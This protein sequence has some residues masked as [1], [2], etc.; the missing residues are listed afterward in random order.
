MNDNDMDF[1][2]VIDVSV[3]TD[4]PSSSEISNQD[5]STPTVADTRLTPMLDE[6]DQQIV[7]E[8]SAEPATP[9]PCV[10]T[11]D[12]II[13]DPHGD[14]IS[15]LRFKVI[16]KKE[17]VFVGKTDAKG[18]IKTIE[19][20]K[21]GSIFEI[22]VQNDIGNY[23]LAAIGKIQSEENY[24]CLTSPKTRFEFTT[25]AHNGESGNA[26]DHKK[27][28]IKSHNQQP[29]DT[30]SITG[31]PD[32]KPTV[33]QSRNGDGHPVAAVIDGAANWYNIH[34]DNAAHPAQD[35]LT[36][37]NTLVAFMEHQATLD[38]RILAPITS[39]E[40]II[41]M[42]K[43]TYV[44]PAEKLPKTTTGWCAKYVKVGLWYAGYGSATQSIGSGV[45]LARQMGPELI[46]AGFKEVALPKVKI[47][48]G[49]Q[50]IEQPDI[51]FAL[52]GDVIVYKKTVAPNEA[53]HIDVRTYHG[54]ISDFVWPA[55][56]GFP[57]VRTYTVLG[58]YRKYSD[59]LSEARVKA[60]LRIIREHEAKGFADPYKAL[61]WANNQH[62]CFSDMSRHPYAES[63]ED[64]P[65]GAYQIKWE[66]FKRD[67]HNTGWATNFTPFDQD[68]AAVY[69]L[70]G[71]GGMA[72]YPRR[73]ALGYIMEGKVE[74]AVNETKLWNLFAF[75]P[76]GGKQQLISMDKLKQAFDTYTKEYS[77]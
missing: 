66:T 22:H 20:L 46:K 72:T 1:A 37:L 58:V 21:L 63:G 13:N 36:R 14:P 15:D 11:L 45:Q 39:D 54:F 25:Y 9:A 70:Q 62:V 26:A 27:K 2:D 31:N 30:P 33:Q 47:H 41:K 65:A 55:R 51:T 40:I 53:G 3:N 76:G 10:G 6:T 29:A 48:A 50:I 68:R 69:E 60:F 32:T 7:Q 74:L 42:R 17:V 19:N 52:P 38:Y 28:V 12:L 64:N 44:E 18:R 59:T 73:T 67:L 77:K 75:L 57:D 43:K 5:E 61:K 8:A 4:N 34:N 23:K 35:A 16:I 71:R 24:A 49:Q 56:N